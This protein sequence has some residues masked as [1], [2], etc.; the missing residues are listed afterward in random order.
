MASLAD[1]TKSETK[2]QS[3]VPFRE[4]LRKGDIKFLAAG[5]FNRD[6]AAPKLDS[7]DADAIVMG[8]WFIANPDLPKRLSEGLPLNPYDRNSFYGADPP[9]KGYVDY[10]FYEDASVKA[11]KARKNKMKKQRFEYMRRKF[12]IDYIARLN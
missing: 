12:Y 1:F 8:R 11:Q 9:T 5:A 2:S 4:L 3:L 10:P 7:G 6:N